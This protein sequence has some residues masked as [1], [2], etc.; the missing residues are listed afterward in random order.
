MP[1]NSSTGSRKPNEMLGSKKLNPWIAKR[2]ADRALP[3]ARGSTIG[4]TTLLLTTLNGQRYLS[5]NN[6]GLAG[7]V[8]N[9]AGSALTAWRAAGLP[10]ASSV[11]DFILRKLTMIQTGW[12]QPLN[13]PSVQQRQRLR[14][15]SEPA[16][17]AATDGQPAADSGLRL[18]SRQLFRQAPSLPVS[19]EQHLADSTVR[20]YSALREKA[21]PLMTSDLCTLPVA[22]QGELPRPS[23]RAAELSRYTHIDSVPLRTGPVAASQQQEDS[24]DPQSPRGSRRRILNNGKGTRTV[25]HG[26]AE[27]AQEKPAQGPPQ[28]Q[29]TGRT[30]LSSQ[31]LTPI[32]RQMTLQRSLLGGRPRTIDESIS[33]RHASQIRS[34]YHPE[35]THSEAQSSTVT[36]GQEAAPFTTSLPAVQ[37]AG[38][39][40][41]REDHTLPDMTIAQRSGMLPSK[42]LPD[43]RHSMSEPTIADEVPRKFERPTPQTM[44]DR[45]DEMVS[46]LP[47]AGEVYLSKDPGVV[48]YTHTPRAAVEADRASMG[49]AVMSRSMGHRE[50]RTANIEVGNGLGRSFAGVPVRRVLPSGHLSSI[51]GS[52]ITPLSMTKSMS[53]TMA[54]S[55]RQLFREAAD[56]PVY[57]KSEDYG[58]PRSREHVPAS[59]D[60][61]YAR[62]PASVW[63]VVAA[64]QPRADSGAARGEELFRYTSDAM[65]QISHSRNHNEL[66]LELAPVGRT[67]ETEATAQPV[68]PEQQSQGNEQSQAAPDI[69]ALA[70]E[71]Y[72]LIRRMVMIERDRHPTWY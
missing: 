30:D 61:R 59:P 68:T 37:S 44:P 41:V 47:P 57:A 21:L 3:L 35:E 8:V 18:Q 52:T 15:A 32:T 26:Q 72:P 55:S 29:D 16:A 45:P 63:P 27:G 2:F 4:F 5:D 31:A 42:A 65:P 19:E 28:R 69:R 70:R 33:D 22:V 40:T 53:R 11:S 64:L 48:P 12:K 10:L 24:D 54:M 14:G 36:A 9:R 6:G 38:E 62:Q 71:V 56:V 50:M 13:L 25:A 1:R 23:G 17:Y 66:E 58:F 49:E 67:T 60:Y 46:R 43:L 51:T 7:Q 20:T 34:A 39:T